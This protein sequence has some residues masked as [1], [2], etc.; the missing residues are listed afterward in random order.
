MLV[1]WTLLWSPFSADG[2]PNSTIS[3]LNELWHST[4]GPNWV[5]CGGWTPGDDP[6]DS[7]YSN[8]FGCNA[9]GTT[10]T[11]LYLGESNLTGTIPDALGSLTALTQL[12]LYSNQLT[13][14][15]P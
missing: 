3:V 15:H 9:D 4:G 7:Q 2:L 8:R 1:V 13:G 12:Y 11:G 6:C 5:A 14:T 10:L